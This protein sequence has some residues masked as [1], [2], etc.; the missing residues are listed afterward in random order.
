M[1]HFEDLVTKL[2]NDPAFADKFHDKNTRDAALTDI[3]VDPHHPG[4]RAALDKIDYDAIHH[5]KMLLNHA[6]V[7][8]YN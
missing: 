8:P 1:A 5:L 4:L 6:P 3:K 2:M 7:R